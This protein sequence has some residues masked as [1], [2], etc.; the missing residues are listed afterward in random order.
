MDKHS[1]SCEDA[2]KFV[3]PLVSGAMV[4]MKTY[5]GFLEGILIT[6][7]SSLK[8]VVDRL[9][10]FFLF[11]LEGGDGGG[12]DNEDGDEYQNSHWSYQKEKLKIFW[13]RIYRKTAVSE[14]T[15]TT[16]TT[17]TTC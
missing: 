7:P 13:M 4:K 6:A 10:F 14:E 1:F 2:S 5:R 9:I 8:S 11:F 16:K 12:K 3:C 17:T 15:T